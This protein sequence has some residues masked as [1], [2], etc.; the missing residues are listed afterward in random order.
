[1]RG[2]RLR[3]SYPVPAERLWHA[4]TDRSQLASW[5]MET[6]FAPTVGGRFMLWPG[7]LRGFDGPVSAVIIEL[8]APTGRSPGRLVMGWQSG[9]TQSLVTWLV[10]PAGRGCRLRVT[11]SGL[12][13]NA[14]ANE[15]L[16]TYQRIF[17]ER[18]RAVVVGATDPTDTPGRAWYAVRGPWR[19]VAA[20]AALLVVVGAVATG[21]W[22]LLPDRWKP[23]GEGAAGASPGSDGLGSAPSAGPANAT[24]GAA[25][26]PGQ[27]APGSTA[28]P[29]GGPGPSPGP[30]RFATGSP[31][32]VPGH[33]TATYT[34]SDQGPLVTY[35][36]DVVVA[37]DGGSAVTGWTVM[38]VLE[39]VNLIV[40]TNPKFVTQDSKDN[41]YTFTPTV[42]TETVLP[43]SSVGFRITI[44]HLLSSVVSC[45]IDGRPCLVG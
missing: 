23:G 20:L 12:L 29:N 44:T 7:S 28:G 1:V 15:L 11:E 4:L 27:A 8:T 5:L 18:L 45:T 17:G 3:F 37:N 31:P 10:R 2:I 16:D 38:F 36:V 30:S 14:R 19:V 42:E 24:A 33:L 13:S 43:G 22:V 26:S 6:D 35:A 25:P 34:L 21:T 9:Q 32:P 41:R 40:A 39:G